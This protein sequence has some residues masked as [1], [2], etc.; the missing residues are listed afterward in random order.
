MAIITLTWVSRGGVV[1]WMLQ[2]S[3][4]GLSGSPSEFSSI[5]GGTSTE[6]SDAVSSS[7]CGAFVGGCPIDSLPVSDRG[8][9]GVLELSTAMGTVSVASGLSSSQDIWDSEDES[10]SCGKGVI[11]GVGVAGA[12]ERVPAAAPM[13]GRS[14]SLGFLFLFGVRG[15]A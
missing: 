12:C 8:L 3:P 15:L 7:W 5:S 4:I 1:D 14:S 2:L 11:A 9:L 6:S 13:R 10:A